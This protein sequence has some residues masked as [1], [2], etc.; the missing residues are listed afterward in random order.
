MRNKTFIISLVVIAASLIGIALSA[1]LI[2]EYF[3]VTPAVADAVCARGS[4]VN[5]CT[6]VSASR[7]A[8]IRGIPLIGDVPVAVMGFIFYGFIAS[9]ALMYIIRRNNEEIPQL[10]ILILILAGAAFIGDMALYFISVFII[11]FVCP[12]CAITYA[13]TA[14]ILLSSILILRNNRTYTGESLTMSIK[15]YLKKHSLN[16]ALIAFVLAAAGIGI[17]AGARV[18]AQAKEAST[19]E[20]RLNVAIR[21]YETAKETDIS[22]AEAPIFGK[23][24]AQAKFVVFFDFTCIHCMDEFLVLEKMMKKYPDAI[25]VTFKF[26]PLHG[27]CGTLEKGREDSDA[28]ACIA[29]VAAFCGHNQ[30]KFMEYARI[31]FDNYHNKDIKFSVKTVREAAK[32]AGLDIAGFDLCFGSKKAREFV[33][34][35]Y[36]ETERLGITS[37]PT[38][39]LNGKKLT[40]DS[41][42][43]DILEGLVNYCVEKKKQMK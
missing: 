5:A 20:D 11:K 19:Y 30:G 26:F 3:G 9:I 40:A 37:T 21:Q 17:G 14:V 34:S 16:F 32:T 29:S 13:A 12:L 18:I 43:A 22:L 38:L 27:N 23:P 25:S 36:L 41:R 4:G 24:S 10:Y 31:L 33:A 39:Y 1:L 6:I 15:N 28:E 7:F 35:E 42:K 8:A 2:F